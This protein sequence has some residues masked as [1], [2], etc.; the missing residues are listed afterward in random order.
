M[1][2]FGK[3]V[4]LGHVLVLGG[5]RS[6]KTTFAE[7][8]AAQ[9]A[10][11][12]C[13]VTTPMQLGDPDWEARTEAD[14]RRRPTDWTITPTQDLAAVFRRDGGPVLVDSATA[15]LTAVLDDSGAWI[16]APGWRE[17]LDR[18]VETT[19]RT[20][21]ASTRSI[22]LVSDEVG[23][24]LVPETVSGRLFRDALGLLNQ[25][26]A[27]T[28]DVVWLVVAGIPLRLK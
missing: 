15:W 27:A 11:V 26:F 21:K 28:A 10:S 4:N 14:R 2:N 16:D 22:L 5:A 25:R 19:L 23:G 24:G 1:A 12:E 7:T 3:K 13:I 17:E 18:A 8:L 9:A 6:G 20:W